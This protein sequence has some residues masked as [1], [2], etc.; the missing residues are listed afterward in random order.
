MI[1]KSTINSIKE[2]I[3]TKLA[4][5]ETIFSIYLV[6]A[7]SINYNLFLPFA[8]A[9]LIAPLLLLKTDKSI[10]LGLKLTKFLFGINDKSKDGNI[11]KEE[12]LYY[13]FRFPSY[14][15]LALPFTMIIAPVLFFL[16]RFTALT[17]TVIRNPIESIKAIPLNWKQIVLCIDLNHP[18]EFIPNIN[19]V[20]ELEFLHYDKFYN[21]ATSVTLEDIRNYF[22]KQ[23]ILDLLIAFFSGISAGLFF[24]IFI[25]CMYAPPL[26]YRFS[27]KA[28]SIIYGPLIWV[29]TYSFFNNLNTEQRIHLIRKSDIGIVSFVYSL[30]IMAMMII[31]LF[32]LLNYDN[33]SLIGNHLFNA[34]I[35][36]SKLPL[37]Q[38]AILANGFITISLF[39]YA[40][41]QLDLKNCS[42]AQ[43]SRTHETIISTGTMI[44][45]LLSLYW[46]IPSTFYIVLTSVWINLP[47]IIN[48]IDTKLFPWQ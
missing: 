9:C 33:I 18:P 2:G 46:I 48:T 42:T 28:T 14:F 40:G 20:K 26:L 7:I 15:F 8:I 13:K 27:L 12:E 24:V 41:W 43:I 11:E 17:Y 34:L 45:L 25:I 30:F 16:I 19:E 6:L 23:T 1:A 31:K 5:G 32:I 10:D 38:L 35:E 44:R 36:P 37:W 3:V 39:F 47:T 21:Y 29:V 4:I 22:E